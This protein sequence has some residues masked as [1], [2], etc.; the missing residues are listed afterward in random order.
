V[1]RRRAALLF[2]LALALHAGIALVAAREVELPV[3]SL[4]AFFD[5][6]IYLEIARSFPLP[7]A[8]EAP[9]YASH[10]PGYPAL[11]YL[12]RQALPFERV[13]WGWLALLASWVPAALAVAVF[14]GL[15]RDLGLRPGLPTLAFALLNPRWLSVAASAHAESLAML[16]VLLCARAQRRG[17]LR[18]CALWL[19]AAGLTRYPALLVGVAVAFG[20]I[21]ERRERR[22]RRLALL[23]IPP[24]AF[25]LLQL[26]LALHLPGFA[27]LREAHRVFW[28][29]HFTWPFASLLGN[30]VAA[31][32]GEPLP[33]A[34]WLS[35]P[36][37]AL[38]L[39]SLLVAWRS[40]RPE[41]R[42]LG[43]WV[44]AVALFHASLSGEWGGYDYARLTLL[45]WPAALLLLWDRFG[46][47]RARW[48][49]PALL[50]A[51]ALSVAAAVVVVSNAVRWQGETSP[52]PGVALRRLSRDE[53][54]WVDHGR[55]LAA[56]DAEPG[57]G[58]GATP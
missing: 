48:L 2:A 11:I 24:L 37:A 57:R 18:A 23:A 6:S 41:L 54:R 39:A 50:A 14:H 10:A 27:G 44:A 8:P 28:D 17:D 33:G 31:W 20:E 58:S 42:G 25:G 29:A 55:L 12:E 19:A 46:A 43:V 16:L 47:A 15:C 45:A 26:Y 40:P 52:W 51:G 56:P 9:H 38:Y 13:N 30:L 34:A 36:A 4:A 22:P 21:A 49:A 7:Y 35:Y 3:A 32:H 53:P 5:G 1:S